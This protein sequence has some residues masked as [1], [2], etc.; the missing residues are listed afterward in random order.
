MPL[1]YT[2]L[3]TEKKLSR[4][5]ISLKGSCFCPRNF[6]LYLQMSDIL[7]TMII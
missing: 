2:V 4:I 7:P 3:D 1:L 6:P 5:Y